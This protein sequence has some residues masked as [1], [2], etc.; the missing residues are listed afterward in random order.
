MGQHR[1]MMGGGPHGIGP[2]KLRKQTKPTASPPPPPTAD[3]GWGLNNWLGRDLTT[4]AYDLRLW[5][6]AEEAGK[7][8]PDS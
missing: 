1:L 7:D 5:E 3:R 8:V 2:L 6:L 4:S